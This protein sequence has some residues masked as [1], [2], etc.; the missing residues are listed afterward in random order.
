MTQKRKLGRDKKVIKISEAGRFKGKDVLLDSERK[1][2]NLARAL[3]EA[4]AET[5]IDV[6]S[7]RNIHEFLRRK[8]G[9]AIESPTIA[10]SSNLFGRATG[11][12]LIECMNNLF[13]TNEF[14]TRVRTAAILIE[15]HE[16]GV[17]IHGMNISED[18]AT[19]RMDM[20]VRIQKNIA[21]PSFITA[22]GAFDSLMRTIRPLTR[23][24][25]A[26]VNRRELNHFLFNAI[27][28]GDFTYVKHYLDR[29]ADINGND[30]MP[31]YENTFGY[32]PLMAAVYR[33]KTR[34]VEILLKRGA[35]VNATNSLGQT[36][37]FIFAEQGGGTVDVAEMLKKAEQ[38][39]KK[40]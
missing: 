40:E 3:F 18:E 28:D 24:A 39:S 6:W 5:V 1:V 15:A 22:Q 25:R 31:S 10:D 19:Q 17:F 8:D 23:L 12:E 16:K 9:D 37:L 20:W 4:G 36:A 35:D 11:Y 33:H 32:T 34:I 2:N 21:N 30:P 14:D 7:S 26:Q 38:R 29:G 27:R 13:S